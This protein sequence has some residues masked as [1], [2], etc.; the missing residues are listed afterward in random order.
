MNTISTANYGGS[1]SF[2]GL[3][4]FMD[5][6]FFLLQKDGR[7]SYLFGDRSVSLPRRIISFVV[8][9]LQLSLIIL[10]IT[11]IFQ[12]ITKGYPRSL[13]DLLTFSWYKTENVGD[14]IKE[15]RQLAKHFEHLVSSSATQGMKLYNECVYQNYKLQDIV[16]RTEKTIAEIYKPS[17]KYEDALNKALEDYYL[18]Y[19]RVLRKDPKPVEVRHG[20]KSISTLSYPFYELLTTVKVRSGEIK[21][22][23]QGNTKAAKGDDQLIYE[24]YSED[25]K[26]GYIIHKNMIKTREA[27]QSLGKETKTIH[28]E[29]FER[30]PVFT[31][32]SIPES[33]QDIGKWVSSLKMKD[34]NTRTAS[35][36][37]SVNHNKESFDT[38]E[39]NLPHKHDIIKNVTFKSSLLKYLGS[40]NDVKTKLKN[41]KTLWNTKTQQVVSYLDDK[42][43]FGFVYLNN[44]AMMEK[45]MPSVKR[46]YDSIMNTYSILMERRKDSGKDINQEH[47]QKLHINGTLVKKTLLSISIVHLYL[48]I[49]RETMTQY[50]EKQYLSNNMF[51]QELWKPFVDDLLV[52]RLLYRVKQTFITHSVKSSYNSFRSAYSKLGNN[53]KKMTKSVFK[54]FFTSTPI[55]QPELVNTD[56]GKIVTAE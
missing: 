6:A 22:I 52:N 28:E 12:L 18:Y 8:L 37:E 30:F 17:L 5:D 25:K 55:E 34:L 38:F 15:R 35:L 29:A 51:F 36:L 43:I 13:Y 20:D 2:N 32:I 46:L 53:L 42:P 9:I 24:V 3:S 56:D 26:N 23:Q 48:N 40:S 44:L 19:D 21:R 16:K 14:F 54:A 49:Y 10:V 7:G 27:L 11:V 4:K 31:Y 47:L 50:L 41:N 39:K 33:E 45:D 1:S